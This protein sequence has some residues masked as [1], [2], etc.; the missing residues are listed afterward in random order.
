M[1]LTE[2]QLSYHSTKEKGTSTQPPRSN[3]GSEV[4]TP[5]RSPEREK[6]GPDIKSFN[7]VTDSKLCFS[8]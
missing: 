8:V 6:Q 5:Y 1:Y 4:L 7:S 2:V 3:W